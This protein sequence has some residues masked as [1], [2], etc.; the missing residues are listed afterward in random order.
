MESQFELSFSAS[1]SQLLAGGHRESTHDRHWEWT[2]NGVVVQVGT[3]SM[4]A[5]CHP[6]RFGV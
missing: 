3:V 4:I 5:L 6:C 1:D 2:P